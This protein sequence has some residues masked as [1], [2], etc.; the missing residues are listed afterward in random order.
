MERSIR[1]AARRFSISALALASASICTSVVHAQSTAATPAVAP[2]AESSDEE[3]VV[4]AQKRSERLADVPMSITALSGD[5]LRTLGIHDVSGLVRVTPG[6]NYV[7]SNYGTPV[8]SIRGLGFYD[9]SL[10]STPA[11]TVYVDQVPLPYP[12]QTRNA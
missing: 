2:T 6:L 8:Y 7:D 11:V 12:Q 9:S 1:L 10:S 5:T 4:T 3:I